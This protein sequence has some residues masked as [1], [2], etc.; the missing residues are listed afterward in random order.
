MEYYQL[1]WYVLL[2]NK[3][4]RDIYFGS[5]FA[6]YLYENYLNSTVIIK[7]ELENVKLYLKLFYW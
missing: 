3:R 7:W 5:K 6:T 4:A 2:Q 1:K